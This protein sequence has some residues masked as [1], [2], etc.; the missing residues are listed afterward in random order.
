[1]III[2]FFYQPHQSLKKKL[3]AL[4][5]V[6]SPLLTLV[7]MIIHSLVGETECDLQRLWI[8]SVM[9]TY[10]ASQLTNIM[11]YLV[12]IHKLATQREEKD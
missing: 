1:M 2:N 6:G 12:H 10:L 8:Y 9:A 5:T 11:A 4:I 3:V 7:Y